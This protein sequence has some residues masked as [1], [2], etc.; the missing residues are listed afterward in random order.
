MNN[1]IFITPS[2]FIRRHPDCAQEIEKL[3]ALANQKDSEC[4]NCNELAWRYGETGLCFSCTTG[5]SDASED[6][7][8]IPDST[9]SN[10][11]TE[12]L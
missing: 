3:N 7:E 4:E 11:N 6:Y 8:L 1:F 9:Q 10:R 12:G 5:E 2:E